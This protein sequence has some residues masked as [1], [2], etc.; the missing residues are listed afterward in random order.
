MSLRV[1]VSIPRIA[2]P[3][4][5]AGGFG[6]LRYSVGPVRSERPKGSAPKKPQVQ[7]FAR[8]GF[9]PLACEG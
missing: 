1:G 5:N 6:A 9:Q 8:F 2:T 7:S 3:R 4:W